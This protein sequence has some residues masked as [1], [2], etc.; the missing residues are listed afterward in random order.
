MVNRFFFFF[1]VNPEFNSQDSNVVLEHE[2]CHCHCCCWWQYHYHHHHR[3]WIHKMIIQ[4]KENEP[5]F[6]FFFSHVCSI[7]SL[8][9]ITNNIQSKWPIYI[10]LAFFLYWNISLRKKKCLHHYVC[11][12]LFIFFGYTHYVVHCSSD[13]KRDFVH[14][15]NDNNNNNNDQQ[16]KKNRLKWNVK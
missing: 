4:V 14:S 3:Q 11:S 9:I 15:N 2:H 16:Q 6:F 5:F 1:V 12:L 10:L 8:I 13:N 7:H